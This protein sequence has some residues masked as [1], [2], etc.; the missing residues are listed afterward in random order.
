MTRLHQFAA[1]GT[2]LP[3]ILARPS[4][5]DSGSFQIFCVLSHVQLCDSMDCSLPGPSDHGFPRQEYWS[6]LS[7]PSPEN[8]PN[9]GTESESLALTG[10]FFTS[11][12]PGKPFFQITPNI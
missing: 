3:H 12:P 10:G 6:G 4:L 9:P 5:C 2:I 11:A 1:L 7:F 8:I